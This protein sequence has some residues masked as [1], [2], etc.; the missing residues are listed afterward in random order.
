MT[1]RHEPGNDVDD[2]M[3]DA[4]PTV[5][6][7]GNAGVLSFSALEKEFERAERYR[8]AALA[9]VRQLQ[10]AQPNALGALEILRGALLADGVTIDPKR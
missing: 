4:Q 3:F 8:A 9:A 2:S 6:L 10:Q 1:K 5:E 7:T